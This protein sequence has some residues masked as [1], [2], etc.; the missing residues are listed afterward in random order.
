VFTDPDSFRLDRPIE[1]LRK[2]VA[3][4]SGPHFCAGAHLARMEARITLQEVIRR[5]PALR[6]NG[7][8]ERLT[9]TFSFWGRKKMPVAWG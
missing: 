3:F 9:T 7:P 6:L 1:E 8:S 5:M 2:H 4:G